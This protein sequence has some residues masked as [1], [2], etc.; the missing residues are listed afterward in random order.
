MIKSIE[1]DNFK[2]LVGFNCT[3]AK[4]SCLIGL[5]GAGKSTILQAVDFLS[6]LMVGDMDAWLDQRGWDK[7]DI[8]SKLTKKRNIDFKVV[9]DDPLWGEIVW[10]GSLYRTKL[11][12]T[13]ESIK[14]DNHSILEVD[15]SNVTIS[16]IEHIDAS[17]SPSKNWHPR[18]ISDQDSFP[19]VLEYQGS[20]L[21]Q[22]KTKQMTP[23]MA[24][25]R[26]QMLAVKSLDLLSPDALR[27]KSRASGKDLGLG[28]EK[29]SAFLHEL[30]QE[31]KDELL[32][33][34][35]QLYPAL[36]SFKTSSLKSGWKEL[37]ITERY[38]KTK[39]T[40]EARHINDGMLRVMAII[41]QTLTGHEFL[42]FDEI[43]N[44]I[45]PELV[46]RIV[47]WLVDAPP[48]I[49]VTTHSPMILNYLD[50]EIAKSG[51]LLVYKTAEGFTKVKPFF[52]IPDM[53]KKLEAMGP[54]EVFVD[55]DLTALVKQID[56]SPESEG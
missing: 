55:T 10:A 39:L 30:R 5:N 50:D 37:S 4:F 44:G 41:A 8:N 24:A 11:T 31:K 54:G 38:K 7:T 13:S 33:R 1:I 56:N 51:V 45:H 21:S 12:C 14:I 47:Q 16:V 27:K 23:P 36:I 40:S 29:L 42:L 17:G 28:G 43:E 2:S 20:I 49:L 53:A 15:D 35:E 32:E 22:L 3:L 18:D 48:Q 26:E 46:E 34:L 52:E 9:I 25:V 19:I 6:Q